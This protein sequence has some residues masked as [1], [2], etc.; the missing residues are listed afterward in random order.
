MNETVQQFHKYAHVKPEHL[1]Q[2]VISS[3][4]FG[5]I[6]VARR[7]LVYFP[8]GI[9]GLQ[10]EK[11]FAF[12]DIEDYRPLTWM[13]STS[14]KYHFPVVQLSHLKAENLDSLSQTHYLPLLNN[15]INSRPP[16][17]VY[18]IVRLDP[19]VKQVSL[20]A[21]VIVSLHEHR[22]EQLI[23]DSIEQSPHILVA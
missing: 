15:L 3:E 7:K 9:P 21:P 13:I 22:G 14:G 4:L 18:V 8:K 20:K 12:L 23:L 11:Q 17:A 5:E 6:K 19:D 1:F 10:E 16:C 2:Q